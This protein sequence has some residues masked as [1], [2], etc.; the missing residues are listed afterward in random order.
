MMS[1]NTTT[2][3]KA[4]HIFCK[5]GT[6]ELLQ[7]INW[8]I[9]PGENWVVFGL[10]GHGKTTLLSIISTYL[11]ANRGDLY[12]FDQ[13]VTAENRLALRQNIGFVSSSFF[14]RYYQKESV[15]DIVLSGKFGHLGTEGNITGEDVRRAKKLLSDWGLKHKAQYPYDLLSQ[16]QRQKVLLARG[17]FLSPKL[18]ILDEP[19]SGMDLVSKELFL[20]Q[21][22]DQVEQENTTII[23]VSHN[24]EEFLPIFNKAVLLKDKGFHSMGDMKTVFSD[25]NLSDFL[26]MPAS[27]KW[28]EDRPSVR[29][30][31][32]GN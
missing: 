1:V 10:N 8:E 2:I 11:G 22:T 12:L 5:L 14:N 26:G 19:C 9:K 20:K 18:L 28:F 6:K 29:V 23:Y 3:M 4:E 16:G 30:Q 31:I 25:D 24:T 32:Q 21:M 7:D 17:L 13:L 15:L 27:V